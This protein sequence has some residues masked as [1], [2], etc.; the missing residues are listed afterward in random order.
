MTWP[1]KNDFEKTIKM[2]QQ[3]KSVCQMHTYAWHISVCFKNRL[4]FYTNVGDFS[5]QIFKAWVI[6]VGKVYLN[7]QNKYFYTRQHLHIL[8]T[9]KLH[10]CTQVEHTDSDSFRVASKVTWYMFKR[11]TISSTCPLKIPN[12]LSGVT[13]K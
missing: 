4:I 9:F 1:L 11:E 7:C 13:M 6:W 8:R 5:Q 10:K 12:E 3:P 2:W